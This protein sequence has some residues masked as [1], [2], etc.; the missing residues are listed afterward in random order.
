MGKYETINLTIENG[1]GQKN[2]TLTRN[3]PS[4][5]Y[6]SL[7]ANKGSTWKIIQANNKQ[8]GYVD[9]GKLTVAQIDSMFINLWNTDALYLIL[10][11][12]PKELCGIWLIISSVIPSILQTLP[13]PIFNIQGPYSGIMTM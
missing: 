3:I 1:E 5:S 4:G 8:F 2:I 6:Y 9:M 13:S 12:I 10:E 7:I 11:I